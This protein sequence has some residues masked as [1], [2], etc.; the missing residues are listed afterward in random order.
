MGEIRRSDKAEAKENR[1]N[2]KVAALERDK[3]AEQKAEEQANAAEMKLIAIQESTLTIM[4]Q[5]LE[6]QAENNKQAAEY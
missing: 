5:M 2:D 4:S 3:K 6:L 1:R